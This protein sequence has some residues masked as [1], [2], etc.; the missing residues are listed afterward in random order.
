[1]TYLNTANMDIKTHCR[2]KKRNKKCKRE[3]C[4]LF[5]LSPPPPFF[6]PLLLILAAK[7]KRFFMYNKRVQHVVYNNVALCCDGILRPFGQ[8]HNISQR[9]PTDV[10]ICSCEKLHPFGR[11]LK[12]QG[13]VH[14]LLCIPVCS[15]VV[16]VHVNFHGN[17]HVLL[18]S[19]D[20]K[21]HE[22]FYVL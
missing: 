5:I 9:D 7:L 6:L 18:C 11:G 4:V 3:S 21:E 15:S 8:L 1:M 17:F 22:N 12:I 14:A 20:V 13:N 16:K 19:T 2:K 10:K